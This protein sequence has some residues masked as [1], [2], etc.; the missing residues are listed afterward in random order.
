[1]RGRGSSLFFFFFL[2]IVVFVVDL[3][4]R[5]LFVFLSLK[6][7]FIFGIMR[8]GSNLSHSNPLPD[9]IASPSLSAPIVRCHMR[10]TF[11]FFP[12]S[13]IFISNFFILYLLRRIFR[14]RYVMSNWFKSKS[15]FPRYI[16]ISCVPDKDSNSIS[17]ISKKQTP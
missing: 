11:G 5:F 13:S 17:Q 16:F 12:C 4:P 8:I 3:C 10:A 1:M 6:I 7:A 2:V 9:T 15:G 14:R